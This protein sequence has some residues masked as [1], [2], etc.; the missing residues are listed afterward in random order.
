[1][2]S[3][4]ETVCSNSSIALLGTSISSNSGNSYLWQ[5]TSDMTEAI[6]H[7]HTAL[8]RR[9]SPLLLPKKYD[10]VYTLGNLHQAT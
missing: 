8:L 1:M 4:P 10:E 3:E 7:I 9:R 5:G 2:V 6:R